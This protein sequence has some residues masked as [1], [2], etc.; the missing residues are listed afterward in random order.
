MLHPPSCVSFGNPIGPLCFIWECPN[1]CRIWTLPSQLTLDQL[2]NNG[3]LSADV[4]MNWPTLACWLR[5]SESYSSLGTV[6][7]D[8]KPTIGGQRLGRSTIWVKR[9][10]EKKTTCFRIFLSTIQYYSGWWFQPI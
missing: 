10:N 3:E 5:V 8:P 6:V 2:N 4:A 1:D 7:A 9:P